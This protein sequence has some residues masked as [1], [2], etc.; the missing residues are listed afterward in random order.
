MRRKYRAVAVK[1]GSRLLLAALLGIGSIGAYSDDVARGDSAWVRRA[2]GERKGRPLP[3]PILEAVR[4]Y[5]TAL[6]ARPESLEARW[7]LLRALHF[8]GEFASQGQDQEKRRIFDRARKVSEKGLDLLAQ[9]IGS[10]V[11]LDEMDSGAI[12]SRL[13]PASVLP[14]DVARLYFWSA[15][16]WGAWSRTVGLLSAVRQ[17]VANRLFRYTQITIALEPEYDAGGAFRLLGR[18]HAKLPRVPFV[19][20]WVDRDQAVPLIER[21]YALAPANP[22]NRLLLALTLL[23]L[24]PERRSEALDLLK[25]VDELTPRPSM[26]I[27]DLAMRQEARDRLTAGVIGE[28]LNDPKLRE[29]FIERVFA[30]WRLRNLFRGRWT[31]GQVVAFHPAHKL[32]LLAHSPVAYREL[33]RLVAA[34][35]R[36]PRAVFRKQYESGFMDGLAHL[37]S[38]GRN[39]NVLQH[40]A[41]HLKD[42]LDSDS[43][44]ELAEL[45]RDYRKSLVPLVVPLTLIGHHIRRQDTDYLK[46]QVF[47]EPHPK[48]LMLRNHV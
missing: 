3:G 8:A 48:E 15:I 7:K 4:S 44:S 6:T 37:A 33:G 23:D 12:K 39:A 13:E 38:R 35:K 34:L 43:R 45:I 11:R 19:S 47:L 40:A 26:R 46:G 5:E 21:A 1:G 18:L 27:E 42:R 25:Q 10:E 31:S 41:G 17:G 22:G 16:N 30:Y 20:G 14:S 9:Q 36:K 28:R 24:A 2:E 32:Q 29:N